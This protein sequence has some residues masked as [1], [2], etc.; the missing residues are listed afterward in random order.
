MY[1]ETLCFVRP[2]G[3][4]RSY[5]YSDSCNLPRDRIYTLGGTADADFVSPRWL[6]SKTR[7]QRRP[8][9][10][11]LSAPGCPEARYGRDPLSCYG[12]VNDRF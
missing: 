2:R 4:Y 5:L 1:T 9:G 8:T 10:V 3:G 6:L 12:N 11:H 7:G